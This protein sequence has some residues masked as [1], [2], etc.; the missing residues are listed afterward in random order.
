[1]EVRNNRIITIAHKENR[2]EAVIC[3]NMDTDVQ[4]F[5]H[6]V[7]MSVISTGEPLILGNAS[8]DLV[9]GRERYIRDA[10]VKSVLC[11]PIFTKD[12]LV[13]ILYLEN[14]LTTS[15]F[16]MKRVDILGKLTAH[17]IKVWKLASVFRENRT[18]DIEIKQVSSISFTER[19][20]KIIQLMIEGLSNLE[21]A[22]RMH[23]S[24]GT[25]KWHSNKIFKKLGVKNRTQAV[26]RISELQG[27]SKDF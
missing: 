23:I 17:A 8:C 21:I 1:M 9:F 16:S 19:E 11:L 24:E 6:S 3:F 15:A 5:S 26:L 18:N 14:N 7:V 25:V 22:E 27:N 13:G 2:D 10:A 20:T 4:L 12:D